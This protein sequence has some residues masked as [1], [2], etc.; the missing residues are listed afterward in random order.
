MSS[1]GPVHPQ[2]SPPLTPQPDEKLFWKLSILAPSARYILA[3]K[4]SLIFQENSKELGW[5]WQFQGQIKR[6]WNDQKELV[7]QKHKS[8]KKIFIKLRDAP[9][10][11]KRENVGILIK[12]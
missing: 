12:Q 11:K 10:P 4:L 5:Y 9:P 2:M 6:G 1:Y 3:D 7:Y 8:I